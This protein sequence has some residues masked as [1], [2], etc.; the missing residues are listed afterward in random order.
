MAAMGRSTTVS[1]RIFQAVLAVANLG[2]SAYV[3]NWYL[4]GTRRG[5]PSPLNF[6]VFAA[7]FSLISLLYLELAPRF[8]QRGAPLYAIFTLEVLNA[9]FFFA[10]FIAYSIFIGNLSMCQGIVCGASRV[11]TVVA[12]AAFCAW[13]ASAALT[14]IYLLRSPPRRPD[15]KSMAMQAA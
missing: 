13:V 7:C 11:D 8:F 12:A 1:L 3:I 9:L 5:S 14:G 2:L 10:G 15:D 4:E 6:L